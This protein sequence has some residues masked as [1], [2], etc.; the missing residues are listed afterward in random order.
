MT[1][2]GIKVTAAVSLALCFSVGG[3]GAFSTS[4]DLAGP[5]EGFFN[6]DDVYSWCQDNKSMAQAY[7]AGLWDLTARAV[8]LLD[9]TRSGSKD[10]LA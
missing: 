10:H 2:S 8:L 3:A 9:S 5:G 7:T 1:Q 4:Y 6:G